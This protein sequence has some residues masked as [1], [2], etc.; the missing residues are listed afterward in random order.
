MLL[1]NTPKTERDAGRLLTHFAV[2]A[3]P[4]ALLIGSLKETPSCALPH[5]PELRQPANSDIY[6]RTL[7]PPPFGGE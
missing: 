6:G 5:R 2:R 7:T 1:N 4:F 3:A